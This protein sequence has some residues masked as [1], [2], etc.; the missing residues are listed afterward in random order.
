[1]ASFEIISEVTVE[2]TGL[3]GVRK[4]AWSPWESVTAPEGHVVNKDALKVEWLSQNGSENDFE[5]QYE[6]WVVIVPGTDIKYPRTL[7]IRTY[8]RSSS[9]ALTGRG[10]T[11]VKI[12]GNYAKYVA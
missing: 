11:K 5:R 7:R 3:D 10:W 4:M 8:V 12:T 9:G 2:Q 6:D 1:M